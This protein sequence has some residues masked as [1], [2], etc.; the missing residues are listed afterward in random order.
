VNRFIF[1]R[2]WV[3]QDEASD[4]ET[5]GAGGGAGGAGGDTDAAAADGTDGVDDVDPDADPDADPEEPGAEASKPKDMLE[6]ITL[7]LK[8]QDGDD[9]AAAK[10]K[11]EEAAAAAKAKP[12][13]THANGKP[14]KDDKGNELDDK[15]QI[16]KKAE[17]AKVK[18]AAEL[19]LKPEE[20]KALGT[21]AQARF[22][23]MVTTLKAREAE[24][25]TLNEQMKPLQ[26]A[27]DTIAGILQETNTTPDQLSAYLEFN[28][29]LQSNDAKDLENALEMV[30]SQ[31]AALYQALGREPADGGVDLLKEFPDLAQKVEEAKLTR[32][33]A[34]EIAQARRERKAAEVSAQQA[35]RG[36]QQQTEVKKARDKGVSD[37]TAW[38]KQL[39]QD[40]IDYPAKKEKLL[41]QV[42][43]VI[44]TYP[45][46][47]WLPTLK[48][49]YAGIQVSKAGPAARRENPIRPSGAKPGGKA[50]QNMYE[51]MWGSQ[52]NG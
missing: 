49:L 31:R 32:E 42:D 8:K 11:E 51:A 19:D 43:E 3:F 22:G 48:L 36:E 2:G 52:G 33:D 40:D 14:K 35:K 18:T 9:A 23:E 12:A 44:K 28:R 10:K 6:A 37:I 29:M 25:A 4:A 39:E 7:G 27:R 41:D 30:E 1:G 13:E 46:N 50:P 38:E 34:L 20:K 47:Q 45:P 5:G 21:K 26:E 17:P 24:I 16:V 15:G